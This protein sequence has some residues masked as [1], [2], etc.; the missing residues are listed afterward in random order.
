[1][2]DGSC[3]GDDVAVGEGK[4]IDIKSRGRLLLEEF[5]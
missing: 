2:L 5:L 1:V 4:L 3:R